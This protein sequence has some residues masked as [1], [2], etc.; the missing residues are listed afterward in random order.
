MQTL[1]SEGLAGDLKIS[2]RN[3][4]AGA[5]D[6][7]QTRP[8]ELKVETGVNTLDNQTIWIKLINEKFFVYINNAPF[9]L[10]LGPFITDDVITIL[11]A[12]K[13]VV[14]QGK[15]FQA[16]INLNGDIFIR[17]AAVYFKKVIFVNHLEV[18]FNIIT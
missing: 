5:A 17:L 8:I 10:E 16:R 7:L 2:M 9:D 14:V 11:L 13:F 12:K 18:K 1:T 4:I 6:T 3:E 15:N